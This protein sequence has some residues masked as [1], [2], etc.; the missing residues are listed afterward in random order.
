MA[1][2]REP[3][4]QP[5]GEHAPPREHGAVDAPGLLVVLDRVRERRPGELERRHH[6][7]DR[8]A[9]AHAER[10]HADGRLRRE[11]EQ[12]QAVRQV[13]P[14]EREARGHERQAEAEHRAEHRP[15]EVA[16]QHLAAVDGDHR[17]R[18]RGARV[19]AGDE[20]ERL[21]R[22]RD[23]E[24]GRERDR[25]RDVDDRDREVARRAL[26]DAVEADRRLVHEADPEPD[27]R[28]Q[29]E[30]L[31][32]RARAGAARRSASRAPRSWR[33]RG[34]RPR[35]AAS[36]V[37]ITAARASPCRSSAKRKSA[38]TRPSCAI[39]TADRDERRQR[40]DPAVVARL[41]VVRVQ[42][43]QEQ[44]REAR[45]HRPEPVDQR[46]PAEAE[47]AACGARRRRPAQ[48]PLLRLVPLDLLV[49]AQH[50]ARRPDARAERG[51]LVAR[52]LAERVAHREVRQVEVLLVDDRRDARVDLE[53]AVSDELH[54][55]EPVEPEL[56]RQPVGGVDEARGDRRSRTTSR[57]RRASPRASSRGR[58][59][60]G[61]RG[62]C[63]RPCA[64]ARRRAPSRAAAGSR[65]GRSPRAPR[66]PTAAAGPGAPRAARS[67]GRRWPRGCG[68]RA[69][70][71]RS[72]GFM[73]MS[74]PG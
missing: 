21:V 58:A 59:R 66:R 65:R 48:S 25:D 15:V 35:I 69:S 55:D 64:R 40:L 1:Q 57:A 14:P 30:R 28:E 33:R 37:R 10:E 39:V 41:Q 68:S 47:Q 46:L 67:G 45:D 6:Q 72:G 43:Q 13:E 27:A 34:P 63:R 3:E 51:E 56:A 73:Q 9:D 24:H 36:A 53:Q 20:P 23:H 11:R 22:E 74:T 5:R 2:Q 61:R 12:E 54:V 19:A 4:H 70:P 17:E 26:L 31:A 32:R 42:R 8:R 44:R 38:L 49:V 60:A 18:D 50:A 71:W 7:R 16:V 29:P 52:D 62:R